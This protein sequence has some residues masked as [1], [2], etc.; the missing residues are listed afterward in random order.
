[1]SKIEVGRFS[2]LFRR[3]LQQKGQQEIAGELSPEI[4][5][6]FVAESDRPDWLFLKNERLCA[7][8]M[9][10]SSGVAAGPT[11]RL[12]NPLGS[13][14]IATISAVH[15][16]ALTNEVEIR[17]TISNNDLGGGIIAI[18]VRDTRNLQSL[19][20]NKSALTASFNT[21]VAP[22]GDR[23]FVGV[24]HI[25]AEGGEFREPIVLTPGRAVDVGVTDVAAAT[26]RA[27]FYWTERQL[28]AIEAE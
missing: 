26:L 6:V 27:G 13:G 10:Q 22:V 7:V 19:G 28:P 5:V 11:L 25:D 8:T 14:V 3:F 9:E 15:Y 23:I 16:T 1:V 20:I 24:A 2:D 18:A 4:S 17:D 12:R 21:T